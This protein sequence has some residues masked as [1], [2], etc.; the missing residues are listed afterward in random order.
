MLYVRDFLTDQ[1]IYRASNGPASPL[2]SVILPTYRRCQS[3]LLGRAI[4]SVLQQ[5]FENFEFI[6]MDD[7]S[8]DGSA[9]LI[10]N[11]QARDSRLVHVRHER[12]SGLPGLRVNE[13]IELAR[14]QYLAFQFDDDAWRPHALKTLVTAI[15]QQSSPCVVV[16]KAQF[17]GAGGQRWHIPSVELNPVTLHE[18]N[19]LANNTVLFPKELA[20]LF[21]MY[22]CHIGMRR[23]CDWDLWLRYIKHVPFIVLDKTISDV[24]ESNPGSIG[25]TVPWDLALFRYLHA[26]PRDRLLTPAYWQ[27]YEVDSLRIGQVELAKDFRRRLYEEHL[28]SYYLKFRHHFPQLE[29]LPA[30]LPR[31]TRPKT[32]LYTKNTYD[33]S[34]DV[35]LGHYDTLANHPASYKM[36]YQPL[37][38]VD[39]YWSAECDLLLLVRTPEESAKQLLEEAFEQGVPIGFYLD[40]D[41][42]T[43]HEFGPQYDYLAPGRPY[44]QNLEELLREVD[45][46]WVTNSFINESVRAYTSRCLPHNN[47][48]RAEWLPTCLRQRT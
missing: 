47:A 18:Q 10:Q 39:S 44:Y 12:N 16:G 21:G 9:E 35:T 29:G 48:V 1:T 3:D 25:L 23:L 7:G 40:D 27:E 32:I 33:V 34:N 8:S 14:G 31:E 45:T 4:E 26:I 36:Y 2:V 28:A 13:G 46:V 30:F 41:L 5:T 42:L 15:Q 19:R 24:F 38:E 6:I 22:D 11:F 17:N 37:S 43:F 20:H